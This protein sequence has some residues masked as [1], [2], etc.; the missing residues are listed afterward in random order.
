MSPSPLW[1]FQLHRAPLR[2]VYPLHVPCFSRQAKQFLTRRVRVP[3]DSDI[4]SS[5]GRRVSTLRS[6]LHASS[7]G[8]RFSIH[9]EDERSSTT[10]QILRSHPSHKSHAGLDQSRASTGV[11]WWVKHH[12]FCFLRLVDM[13]SGRQSK[14]PNM[15]F[16]T[17]LR[18]GP[19]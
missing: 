10:H 9:P 1:K 4:M 8:R 5:S 18:N 11:I 19:T 16:W 12:T 17:S 2:A 7:D 3:T 13:H 6:A 14:P 15:A